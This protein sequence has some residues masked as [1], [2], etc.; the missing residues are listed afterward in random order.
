MTVSNE[1]YRHDY[2]GNGSTVLF[3]IGFGFT[4]HLVMDSLTSNGVRWFNPYKKIHFKGP[5]KTGGL[6]ELV[7]FVIFVFLLGVLI[8][9]FGSGLIRFI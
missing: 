5:V 7:L 3:A 1:I 2:A 6:S 9:D 8:R 4:A